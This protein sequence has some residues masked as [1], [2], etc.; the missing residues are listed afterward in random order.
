MSSSLLAFSINKHSKE[1]SPTTA[2]E[3][4]NEGYLQANPSCL[5]KPQAQVSE[6][7][8]FQC[9]ESLP[10]SENLPTFEN[11]DSDCDLNLPSSLQNKAACLSV[12]FTNLQAELASLERRIAYLSLKWMLLLDIGNSAR[13]MMAEFAD[14]HDDKEVKE[15]LDSGLVYNSDSFDKMLSPEDKKALQN[16]KKKCFPELAASLE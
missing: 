7:Q 15:Y 6:N 10:A 12:S 2:S 5:I 3:S 14:K 13:A 16:F 9:K 8:P 1:N 11:P 4:G